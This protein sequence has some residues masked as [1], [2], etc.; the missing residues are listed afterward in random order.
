MHLYCSS[1]KPRE[2]P[3]PWVSSV[4]SQ[5]EFYATFVSAQVEEFV[6]SG[7]CDSALLAYGA[8]GSGKTHSMQGPRKV[9]APSTGNADSNGFVSPEDGILPRC[10]QQMLEVRLM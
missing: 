9:F 2:F 3:V 1:I 7:T 10:I 8:T 4:I 5:A 6:R